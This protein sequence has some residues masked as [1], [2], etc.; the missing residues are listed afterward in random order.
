[1]NGQ[2]SIWRFSVLVSAV[3]A[4]AAIALGIPAI[5][6]AAGAAAPAGTYVGTQAGGHAFV[7]VL[8]GK[9]GALRAYVN[10]AQRRIEGGSE[11]AP[12]GTRFT[13]AAAATIPVALC[14]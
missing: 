12:A 14:P 2:R 10:G 4:I 3:A 8:V 13:A 5:G 7:A 6:A 1:M 11:L 9:D